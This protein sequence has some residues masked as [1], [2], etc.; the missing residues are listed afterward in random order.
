MRFRSGQLLYIR[1]FQITSGDKP[2]FII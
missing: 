1:D 2:D